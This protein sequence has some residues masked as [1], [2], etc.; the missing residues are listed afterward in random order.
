MKKIIFVTVLFS[1]LVCTQTGFG[2][3]QQFSRETE[4]SPTNGNPFDL[5]GFSV[6]ISGNIA[7]VG[8]PYQNEPTNAGFVSIFVLDHGDWTFQQQL[9]ASDASVGDRF[10]WAVALSGNTLV[11]TAPNRQADGKV[12]AAYVFERQGNQW[13]EKTIVTSSD[14]RPFGFAVAM[15]GKTF[16]VGAVEDH[17]ALGG[18]SDAGLGYVFTR[19]GNTW[20]QVA[21]LNSNDVPTANRTTVSVDIR[22]NTVVLGALQERSA[23]PGAVYVFSRK[24]NQWNQSAQLDNPEPLSDFGNVVRLSGPT[25]AV[26][27]SSIEKVFIFDRDGRAWTLDQTILGV[28]GTQFGASLDFS[29]N[30]LII[31]ARLDNSNGTHSGAAHLFVRKKQD[32]ILQQTITPS[33]GANE[34][35]FGNSVSLDGNRLLVGAPLHNQVGA[36]YIFETGK[37]ED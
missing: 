25:I 35:T 31:G 5:F 15:D 17:V 23:T 34:D 3:Q 7:V 8:A 12:G 13:T 29:G 9:F 24:G 10:G 37:G 28:T 36:A 19:S 22:A 11:V 32:W 6:A 18:N 1:A 33:D 26:A 27:A 16:V 14:F 20:V 2:A 21:E 4:L 30:K